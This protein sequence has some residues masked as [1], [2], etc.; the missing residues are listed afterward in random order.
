MA[1]AQKP[2][3]VIAP[4]AWHVPSHYEPIAKLLRNAG[5]EV[6]PVKH[7]SVGIASDPGTMLHKDVEVVANT[8]RQLVNSG[9]DVVLLM[10]SYGGV[11]GSEAAAVV[12][13]EL[14]SNPKQSAGRIRRLVY[15]A[16]HV[17][18]KGVSFIE[19]GRSIPNMDISRVFRSN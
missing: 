2:T 6:S 17:I 1:A 18:N 12:S 9:K 3:I 16:A 11:T 19:S 15:L 4:G 5:Y 13:E 10:H 14:R 8:L 7:P